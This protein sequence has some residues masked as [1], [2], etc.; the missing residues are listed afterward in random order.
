LSPEVHKRGRPRCEQ[1]RANILA[2]TFALLDEGGPGA[3]TMDAIAQRA[4]VSKATV[5][6][7]WPSRGWV[8]LESLVELMERESAFVDTGSL[9]TDLRAQV[10]ALA[11]ILRTSSG[12][13]IAAIIAEMQTDPEIGQAFR[14]AFLA[15]RR[16]SAKAM[17]ARA[18]ARGE[19]RPG[20]DPELVLDL[21]YAP[22]YLRLLLKHQPIDEAFVEQ[23]L[24]LVLSGL[25][26]D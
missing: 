21:L 1:T 19:L 2:A 8:I 18:E 17:L 9:A 20:L 12:S 11:R 5:Y 24:R 15:R 22:L 10:R 4:G 26:P 3:A 25:Q 7:W 16:R 6:R 14:E 23:S 13:S